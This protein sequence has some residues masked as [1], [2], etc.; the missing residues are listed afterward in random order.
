MKLK[1]ESDR[2]SVLRRRNKVTVL[3]IVTVLAVLPFSLG[4]Y[5]EF[6]SPGPFDSGAN[7]YSAK[8]VLDGA[9]IGVSENPSARPGTL[10]INILGVWL[11]GF[12]E[13]GPK[14]LQ[15]LIQA[16]AL[17]L[18]FITMRKLYGTF[19]AA[20]GVILTSVYLS[21]PLIAK[22]GN[23]KM[24]YTTAFM[25]L[26][27]SCF[28]L[29]Q[30]EE[31]WWYAVLS[32]GFIIWAPMFKQTGLSAI[33][34]IS[35][36]MM[37]Q[38]LLG[39]KNL[40]QMVVDNVLLLAGA[41][42]AIGPLYIWIIGWKVQMNLPYLFVWRAVQ[43]VLSVV[44]GGGE[45]TQAVSRYILYSRKLVSFSEQWP[46][47]LRYYGL[48]ILP[49][50]LAIGAI[51]AGVARMVCRVVSAGQIKLR[52]YEPFVLLFGVWWVLDMGFVWVS[53]R[54]YEQ[55]YLA[56][57]AS[58]AMLGGYLIAIYRDTL[59]TSAVHKGKRLLVGLAGSVCMIAM[60]WHIFFGIEKSPY[61][62]RSY[63]SK[64]RGYVQRLGQVYRRRKNNLMAPWEIVGRYIRTHSE[65]TDKIYVWGW[66]PGIYVQAQ[67]YSAASKAF[68]MPRPTPEKMTKMIAGL[69][70]QFE[71]EPPEF[72]VDPRKRHIPTERPP[73][74][75]WPRLP[76]G[77]FGVQKPTFL[78][79][80]EDAIEAYDKVWF[81]YLQE[82]FGEDEALRFKALKPFRMFAMK[83][84][85]IV[86]VFGEHVLFQLKRPDVNKQ[87]QHSLFMQIPIVCES[88]AIIT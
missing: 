20:V 65:P 10:L 23:D 68:M 49:I 14:L 51:V 25:I 41:A 45:Q 47:V 16:A 33:G 78:P 12:N 88:I 38:T 73:Y 17:L 7:V 37:V 61:T 63:G 81:E 60:S 4:K 83:N 69:L 71:Q 66:Y 8:R 59:K 6:N 79:L 72:I 55:Y 39:R 46:I 11:C 9:R 27:V 42:V 77:L 30:L 54:S 84:Y 19:P 13:T 18:M 48:L 32:G 1:C 70:A 58:A 44:P 52:T 64:R 35:L 26:G 34:A 24:Q 82:N 74:E 2:Q 76:K 87:S 28:V 86:K 40:K 80:D 36:F 85:R 62:G 22:F 5:F 31:R 15:M 53:P 50:S 29:Y 56:L 3:V 67:R 21:A 43:K 75:L 57:N